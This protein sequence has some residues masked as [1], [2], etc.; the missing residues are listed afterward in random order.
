MAVDTVV[1]TERELE[2]LQ[3]GGAE[4]LDLVNQAQESDAADRLLTIRAALSKYK[5]A[6]FWAMFLSTSL[7][8]E[9]YDLVIITSFYGQ[10]Q[11]QERFGVYDPATKHNLIPAAWQSGLSNSSVVGQLAGLIVNMYAQDHFGCRPT[12]MFFM[13]WMTVTIFIP[14]FAPS[15][16]VLAFGEAMCGV[17]WGVFQTLSTSYACE[18][19]PTVLRPYVTAYVCMCWGAGILLSSGVVRA[20]ASLEGDIGWRLPF[21]IQWVWPIPLLIGA[22]L[23]PESPWNAVRRGQIGEAR[24]A[25]L[26]L[27]QDTPNKE[28]DVDATLAYIRY[29]TELEKAETDGASIWDCFKGANL[30]RTEINC[31]VWAAQILCGNAILGYSVTFLE[32]AGFTSIQAFDV[33]IALSACYIIGGIIC[34]F[35]FPH[36]GRA[37][38]YMTGLTFM[39]FCLIAIGGLGWASGTQ[40]QLAVGIL[41]VISTLV[42]MITIG[43]VCYPIVAETPSGRLRYKTITIGR[44]VYNLTGIFQNSVTPHMISS[45]SWNWG[46]KTALFYAGTNLLCNL[47]CW[48]RLPET[49]DRTFGEIDLLFANNVPARKF[50]TTRVEQFSQQEYVPKEAEAGVQSTTHVEDL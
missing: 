26:R 43:P 18:V 30:R 20:V 15:L 22:Y 29:T 2:R 8:M 21:A 47:W 1:L 31:V 19:V 38:I 48:F 11:F 6:V 44:F 7:I 5:K 28:R 9:G 23:A 24:E 32:A 46:A 4:T 41:L 50:R 3:L 34:W 49:K 16:P 40:S 14:V 27:R 17:S 39:F 36:F 45:T 12:M 37:T 33:N 35:L 10:T 42:N 13:A 25:L